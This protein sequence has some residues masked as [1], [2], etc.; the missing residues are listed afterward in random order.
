MECL[1]L[2]AYNRKCIIVQSL[3]KGRHVINESLPQCCYH[4]TTAL[5]FLAVPGAMVLLR[6][7]LA[8]LWHGMTCVHCVDKLWART[9]AYMELYL[10]QHPV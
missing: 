9:L 4:D 3:G 8:N 6:A 2:A 7:T 1:A 10:Q 5:L